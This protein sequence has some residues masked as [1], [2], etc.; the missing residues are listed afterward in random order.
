MRRKQQ[1]EGKKE[2]KLKGNNFEGKRNW[3][4]LR[5]VEKKKTEV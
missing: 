3:K 2:R 4:I 1:K 5:D